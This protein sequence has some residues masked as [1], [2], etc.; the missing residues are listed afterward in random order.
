M[1][2]VYYAWL[3]SVFSKKAL[4]YVTAIPFMIFYALFALV[5]YP[6][7]GLIHPPMPKGLDERW[8][9]PYTNIIQSLPAS[10]LESYGETLFI[11][12]ASAT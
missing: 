1:F 7:R 10:F 4:F 12:T 11:S 6:N 9:V 8:Q 2:M 3:S 5:L